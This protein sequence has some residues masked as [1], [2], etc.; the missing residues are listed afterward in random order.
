MDKDSTVGPELNRFS[1]IPTLLNG[2]NVFAVLVVLETT[3]GPKNMK[4][5]PTVILYFPTSPHLDFPVSENQG[6]VCQQVVSDAITLKL[7]SMHVFSCIPRHKVLNL[8]ANV[9]AI[10]RQG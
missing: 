4:N 1:K 8:S 10:I 6:M 2:R 9:L 7:L 3:Y 5:H